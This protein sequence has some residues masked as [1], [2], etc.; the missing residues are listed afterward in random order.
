MTSNWLIAPCGFIII[1]IIIFRVESDQTDCRCIRMK[2]DHDENEMDFVCRN[3][4]LN[5]ECHTHIYQKYA[6]RQQKK[7]N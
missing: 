4:S 5:R 6:Q 1:I 3:F 7:E 2:N